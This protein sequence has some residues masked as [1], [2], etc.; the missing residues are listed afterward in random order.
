MESNSSTAPSFSTKRF[1]PDTARILESLLGVVDQLER[2][3]R[4]SH[5]ETTAVRWQANVPDLDS[6]SQSR[7]MT[8]QLQIAAIASMIEKVNELRPDL[9]DQLRRADVRRER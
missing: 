6:T 4:M 9:L 3:W 8:L 7:Q 2:E 1:I 5:E